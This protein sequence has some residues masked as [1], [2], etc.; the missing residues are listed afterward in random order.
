MRDAVTKVEVLR[1]SVQID[2]AFGNDF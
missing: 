2:L 1:Q